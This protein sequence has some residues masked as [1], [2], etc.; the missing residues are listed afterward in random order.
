MIIW[1]LFAFI[2]L[3]INCCRTIDSGKIREE[4]ATL[5][6]ADIDAHLNKNISHLIK[7][8]SDNYFSVKNGE[9]TFPSRQEIES[10]FKSYLDNTTFSEYL[11]LEEPVIGYSKDGSLIWVIGKIKVAGTQKMSNGKEKNLDFICSWITL[12]ERRK[13]ELIRLG[14]VSTFK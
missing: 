4:I 2:F 5:H 8:V 10:D 3:F 11:E 14:D 6:K 7:N 13:N 12:Y 9:I 1:K